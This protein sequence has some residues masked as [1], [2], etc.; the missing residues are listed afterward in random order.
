MPSQKQLRYLGV[1]ASETGETFTPPRT[2]A[3]A[4]REIKRLKSRKQLSSI[5]RRRENLELAAGA[6]VPRGDA[7]RVR[8]EE[9]VGYGSTAAWSSEVMG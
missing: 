2:K 4:S 7:A 5:D 6:E 9:L 1:L 3:Q 8:D